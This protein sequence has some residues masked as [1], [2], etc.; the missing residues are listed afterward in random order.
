MEYF[1]S[2]R[3]V[4]GP[5]PVFGNKVGSR[6]VYVSA[7]VSSAGQVVPSELSSHAWADRVLST[8]SNG[9]V[10]ILV[11]GF[12]ISQNDLGSRLT[13]I[14]QTLQHAGYKGAVVAFDWPSDGSYF[15]YRDDWVD[16]RA[17]A[18]FLIADTVELLLRHR[19]TAKIHFIAH[20]MGSYVTTRA[21]ALATGTA[22]EPKLANSV[23]QVIF[24]GSDADRA[25]FDDDAWGDASVRRCADRLTNYW[26]EHDQALKVSEDVYHRDT[27]R[28]GRHQTLH[29]GADRV[30]SVS[31]G[32]YY[33][34]KYAQVVDP[35]FT[36]RW[37]YRDSTFYRDLLTTLR[38]PNSTNYATRVSAA[39]GFQALKN[40]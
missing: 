36:H 5:G 6:P 21:F 20:S 4:S 10:V 3:N 14:R 32:D 15:K 37:Y 31:C 12:N 19:P 8:S 27:F 2:R 9:H 29:S 33:T 30:V 11:H 22:Q 38:H 23:G 24:T 18:G 1:A 25:W 39:D 34:A 13:A 35:S 16:A 28:F 26:S 17:C 7:T 40:G